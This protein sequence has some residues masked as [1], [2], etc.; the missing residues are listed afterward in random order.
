MVVVLVGEGV[1]VILRVALTAVV[2]EEEMFLLAPLPSHL[3]TTAGRQSMGQ[4]SWSGRLCPR[5]VELA[6]N[7]H[8][9]KTYLIG[10]SGRCRVCLLPMLG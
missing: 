6:K 4:S 2:E 3:A 7:D 5:S 8:V 10:G 9:L 1:S